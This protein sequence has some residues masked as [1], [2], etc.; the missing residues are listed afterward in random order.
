MPNSEERFEVIYDQRGF[1]G[2]YSW[3]SSASILLDKETGVQYLV[4]GYKT[5]TP[6]LDSSGKPVVS[7]LRK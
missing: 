2:Y 6:L 3:D 1:P 4:F 7:A 5:I